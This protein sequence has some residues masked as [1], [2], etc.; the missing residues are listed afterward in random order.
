MDSINTPYALFPFEWQVKSTSHPIRYRKAFD[1][2][3][4]DEIFCTI[5]RE[6]GG[7]ISI[8]EFGTMLGFNPEDVAETAIFYEYL[9]GLLEYS[10]IEK[11]KDAIWLTEAGEEALQSRLKYQ[12]YDATTTLYE[13]Y[14]ATGEAV[15]FSFKKE[16]GLENDIRAA[17]RIEHTDNGDTK[18]KQ[19]LAFQ[20][21][22]NDHYQ[23]ELVE[24]TASSRMIAY[25][26]LSLQCDVFATAQTFELSILFDGVEKPAI[27]N[28]I[29][30]PENKALKAKLIREGLF[31]HLLANKNAIGPQDIKTY[32]DLWNWKELAANTKVD[33]HLKET[34]DLFR[35]NGDGSVW[36]IISEKVPVDNIRPVIRIYADLWNWTVLTSRLDERFIRDHIELFP[37]DFEELSYKN[38]TL[39]EALLARPS[40]KNK[41]WDWS[42]LSKTLPDEF[43]EAHVDDFPWN[44]SIITATKSDVLRNLLKKAGTSSA[45]Y[46]SILQ[47]KAW[48]WKWISQKSSEKFLYEHIAS[49]ANKIDWP[50][51]LN[52]FFNNPEIMARCLNDTHFKTIFNRHL[53]ANYNAAHEKYNWTKALIDL[54]EEQQLLQWPSASYIKGFE[55]NEHVI[56]NNDI[57]N[58]YHQKITTAAGYRNVS[59][60]ISDPAL[61]EAYPDF[62]WNW[63]GISGNKNLISNGTFVQAAFTGAYPFSDNL[64]WHTIF[65]NTSYDISLW[66]KHL[67]RFY[68]VSS[69][70]KHL[71]FWQAITKK[72]EQAYIFTNPHLPWDWKYITEN[73]T[74]QTI[75]IHFH[76]KDIVGKWDWKIATR[77]IDKQTILARLKDFTPYVD[78]PYLIT[79]VFTVDNELSVD[80]YLTSIAYCLSLLEP[81]KQKES[82][83][84]LTAV[85]PFETLF[86]YVE[87]SKDIDIFTWNWDLISAH[88]L[89]PTDFGTFSRYRRKINWTILSGNIAI[90]QKFSPD[91]WNNGKAWFHNTNNYL[92]RFA[93]NWDWQVL[94]KNSD[95]NGARSIVNGYRDANWDWEY[96]SEFGGFLTRIKR[97]KDDYLKQ[98]LPQF[99]KLRFDALSKRKDLLIDQALLIANQYKNWDWQVL[100]INDKVLI[101]SDLLLTLKDKHWN[102]K[103]LSTRRDINIENNTLLQ[104]AD[105]DWDWAQLS[106]NDNLVFDATFINSTKSKPWNWQSVSRHESFSPTLEILTLC[107]EFELDWVYLSQSE[108][109]NPTKELLAKFENKWDWRFITA[110]P[111][112]N[113]NDLDFIERFAD[114]WDWYKI[115]ESGKLTLS[116]AILHRFKEHLQWDLISSNTNI[117]FTRE[118][119]Q[120]FKAYWD[121]TELKENTRAEELLG[122]YIKTEIDSSATLTFIDKIKAQY[123]KW[124]GSVYHFS[125]IENAVDII[126]NRTIKSRNKATIK[127]DAAGNVVHRRQDAHDYVRFYF[128]PNT[129]TQFYNEYLG[130]NKGDGYKSKEGDWVSWYDR[131]KELG[132]PKCPIPI[133]FRFSLQEVLFNAGKTCCISNGNM[134]T[135]ATSFGI[136]DNMIHKFNFDDLF[137]TP[138]EYAT[139][140][141]YNRYRNYSQQEFLVEDEL[142]FD[143]LTDFEIVCPTETDRA[144]LKHLLGA[145]HKELF[146]KIVVNEKYYNNENPRVWVEERDDTLRISTTFN[147]QGYFILSSSATVKDIEIISGEVSKIEQDKIIFD[148]EISIKNIHSNI[149]LDFIDETNRTWFIYAR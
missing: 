23:G 148:R 46:A 12:Y 25:G 48:D 47:S 88:R 42:Y 64:N 26:K 38:T 118:N 104:L 10:L 17:A 66:N 7:I 113:F 50:I 30:L 40:L 107:K 52:R 16:L 19:K 130:K 144:L 143:N 74:S 79:E 137:Y 105:K 82:W 134:Q 108:K 59:R 54:F 72:E 45:A 127:G 102:W 24:W 68:H 80:N 133:F 96:L 28:L 109:L 111:T 22:E 5:I 56:W 99:P 1:I 97:D 62:A 139:K 78:W 120:Q 75:L 69:P 29:D 87:E 15:D 103:A 135:T 100:S 67:N 37:W 125:H 89:L 41:D 31:R 39:V 101:S 53:P 92:D 2:N 124:G 71:G 132:H 32:I 106:N 146:S 84:A 91:N 149:R 61:P 6:K 21:F 136:I 43:I 121:W 119:I 112:I 70:E 117:D 142:S 9:H 27:T 3:D 35:N 116:E 147:G 129:P 14:T 126:K 90:A 138:E 128:R 140:S 51:V 60:C 20:L 95:I 122:D 83:E 76:N 65:S 85:Y 33:W 115:C 81:E 13:N 44:F 110:N 86:R 55:S 73:S 123:S 57:F 49:F 114:K 36:N 145:E 63:E 98:L 18:E 11:D 8:S 34:F 4:I 77:K 131:A 94:S 93:N 141:D 58:S